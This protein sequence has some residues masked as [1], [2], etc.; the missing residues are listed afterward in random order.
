[1]QIQDLL[2]EESR[3]G[4]LSCS[5]IARVHIGVQLAKLFL[6]SHLRSN[7]REGLF[8]KRFPNFYHGNLKNHK[9]SPLFGVYYGLC[10]FFSCRLWKNKD[11][12]E[13]FTLLR[14]H[15]AQKS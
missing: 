10:L 9:K 1:M 2:G 11:S 12:F 14:G 5:S 15:V 8:E 13:F 3:T 4:R 7:L 6:L